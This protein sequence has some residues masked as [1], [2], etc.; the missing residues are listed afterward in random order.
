MTKLI[1]LGTV[2]KRNQ[3]PVLEWVLK[4]T[5]IT[6]AF[7]FGMDSFYKIVWWANSFKGG[8]KLVEFVPAGLEDD[9]VCDKKESIEIDYSKWE[10]V[11][12]EYLVQLKLE[13]DDMFICSQPNAT[14][15]TDVIDKL[16]SHPDRC[17]KAWTIV[18]DEGNVLA[19]VISWTLMQRL[20]KY[21]SKLW[22]SKVGE[23]TMV[24]GKVVVDDDY[25][26]VEVASVPTTRSAFKDMVDKDP[27]LKIPFGATIVDGDGKTWVMF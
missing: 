16:L 21:F 19:K 15:D 23:F 5:K 9:S 20:K 13:G 6:H 27:S 14:I 10:T 4:E 7:Y 26:L 3:R 25:P 24:G 22:E 12:D 1:W 18:D 17:K 11:I 8:D 2:T